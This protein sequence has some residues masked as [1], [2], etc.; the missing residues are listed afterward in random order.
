M[1][2]LID[3]NNKLNFDYE[4]SKNNEKINNE[5]IIKKTNNSVVTLKL[6]NK[7]K[8]INIIDDNA[9]VELFNKMQIIYNIEKNTEKIRLFGDIYII[10][11]KTE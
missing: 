4:L 3:L 6:V 8:N 10:Q 2:N 1:L 9:H 11:T 7:I 5:L